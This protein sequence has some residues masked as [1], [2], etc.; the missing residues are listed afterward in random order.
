MK[1]NPGTSVFSVSFKSPLFLVNKE[2]VLRLV[3]TQSACYKGKHNVSAK[4]CINFKLLDIYKHEDFVNLKK[5]NLYIRPLFI[6]RNPKRNN[7]PCFAVKSLNI[8]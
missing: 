4:T 2:G 1:K 5:R 8:E 3:L 7:L 6:C